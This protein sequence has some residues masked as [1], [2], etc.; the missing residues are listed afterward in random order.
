MKKLAGKSCRKCSSKN[1]ALAADGHVMVVRCLDCTIL[2]TFCPE[3][4]C[5]GRML[6]KSPS[7]KEQKCSDCGYETSYLP[8]PSTQVTLFDEPDEHEQGFI[9][10][11][12]LAPCRLT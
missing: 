4:G 11:V 3:P 7:F 5:S 9:G 2:S 1:I 10:S 12:V 6:D 8:R